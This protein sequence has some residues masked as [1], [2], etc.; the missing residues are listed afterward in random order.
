[1]IMSVPFIAA[2]FLVY[3]FL[4]ELRNLHGK[5]LLGYLSGLIVGYSFMAYVQLNGWQLVDLKFRK[6]IGLSTYYSLLSAFFWSNIIAYDLH[7]NF[8]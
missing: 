4:P 6:F 2:T 3:L 5:C 1:M 8:R 7:R